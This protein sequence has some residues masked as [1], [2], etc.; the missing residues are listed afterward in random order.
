MKKLRS[1]KDLKETSSGQMK[2]REKLKLVMVNIEGYWNDNMAICDWKANDIDYAWINKMD[3]ASNN[4][5]NQSKWNP[6]LGSEGHYYNEPKPSWRPWPY[7][8]IVV[9]CGYEL[10]SWHWWSWQPM[11]ALLLLFLLLL[12]WK[13]L[14]NEVVKPAIIHVMTT[15]W[16]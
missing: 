6:V 12:F 16:Y 1:W 13:P 15:D 7:W 10:K 14:K 11:W 4:D 9:A 2:W 5:G 3:C 8:K